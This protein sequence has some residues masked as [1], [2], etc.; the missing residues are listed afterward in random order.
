M[1]SFDT[2]E[3]KELLEPRW[4]ESVVCVLGGRLGDI[5]TGRAGRGGGKAC[6]I[7]PSLVPGVEVAVRTK[8]DRVGVWLG[9]TTDLQLVAEVGRKLK[10]QLG[11][12]IS[13]IKFSIH[14]EEKEGVKRPCLRI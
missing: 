11:T 10:A 1:L 5:V 12:G 9:A 4:V 8:M 13:R 7:D 14:R 2:E 6:L 3:R